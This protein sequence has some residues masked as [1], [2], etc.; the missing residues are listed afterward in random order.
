MNFWG[1][2]FLKKKWVVLL[3]ALVTLIA[4]TGCGG[5]KTATEI[6]DQPNSYVVDTTNTLTKDE[7]SVLEEKLQAFHSSGEAEMYLVMVDSVGDIP[8]SEYTM[9][10]A[11]KWKP[12]KKD[13]DNGLIVLIA[14]QDHKMRME[15]GRGLEGVITDGAAGEILDNAQPA[16]RKNEYGAGFVK[17]VDAT[18][19]RIQHS[20]AI[21]SAMKAREAQKE[22]NTMKNAKVALLIL[23]TLELL[24]LLVSWSIQAK[25][26]HDDTGANFLFSLL[27]INV[28]TSALIE[29]IDWHLNFA[30]GAID[31][32]SGGLSYVGSSGGFFDGG[33]S[34]SS[35]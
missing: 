27:C 30:D 29:L 20:E 3:M 33:G 17:I 8:I 35:W 22:A 28:I 5:K 7:K 26:Y 24:A 19:A 18:G 34:D 9:Q 23:L 25:K 6:P 21:D 32:V 16:F 10:I 11:E 13:V 4:M 15:V 31:C 2:S 14:K 12:G 1:E